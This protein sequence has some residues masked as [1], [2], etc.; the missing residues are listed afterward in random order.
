[1]ALDDGSAADVWTEHLHLRGAEAVASYA[2][3]PLP[4]T[5][6]VTRHPVGEGAAWYVA[7]RL[8]AAGTG[9]LV[10][11]LVEEAGVRPVAATRP[12]VEVARRT[13]EDGRSWLFVLNH[14]AEP[15]SVPC[16]GRDLV[17]DVAVDEAVQVPAGG[18]A[19]VREL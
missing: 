8:D 4:G 1:M 13:A 19:V 10:D 18:V 9:R 11:L 2:D 15:A 5:P 17:T 14:T 16:S 6:A 3:G 12:G 7:C